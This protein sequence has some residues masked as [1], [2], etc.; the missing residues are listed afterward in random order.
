M[1][2]KEKFSIVSNGIGLLR[3]LRY[4]IAR[5]FLL[6]IYKALLRPLET[7]ETNT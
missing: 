3:K 6:S 2:L 5:K 4:S 7:F 1:H